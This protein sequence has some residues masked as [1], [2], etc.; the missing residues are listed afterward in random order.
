MGE[1]KTKRT[2]TARLIERYPDCCL[3]G[4]TR[5]ATTREHIP[6]TALFDGAH[7]PDKLVM[8]A[9]DQ[10]NRTTST[11]DLVASIIS[12]W[13]Y[14]LDIQELV[15][16]GRLAARIKKQAPEIVAESIRPGFIERKR[17]RQHLERHGVHVPLGAAIV[18]IG[19]KAID[20][21]TCSPIK[22]LSAYTLS[23]SEILFLR[24]DAFAPIGERRKI[25]N[26]MVCLAK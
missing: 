16:H 18:A 7:R 1:A 17:G 24:P 15:D 11:A 6:P 3:C 21:L 14:E 13:R 8:P 23:I 26:G 22:W 12:R 2:A 20:S 5:A 4:G 10:C 9:C 19:D 25:I